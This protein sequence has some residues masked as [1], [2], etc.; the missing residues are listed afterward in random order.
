MKTPHDLLVSY[1]PLAHLKRASAKRVPNV[2]L[3]SLSLVGRQ[4]SYQ[5]KALRIDCAHLTAHLLPLLKQGHSERLTQQL[6]RSVDAR[7]SLHLNYQT[8]AAI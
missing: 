7:E 6:R 1:M 5:S 2:A 4:L 3:L 8:S